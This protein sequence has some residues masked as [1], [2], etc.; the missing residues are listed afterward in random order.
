MREEGTAA[1]KQETGGSSHS[2]TGRGR[3]GRGRQKGDREREREAESVG[4][5]Q[6]GG[7]TEIGSESAMLMDTG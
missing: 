1:E 6:G 5:R 2:S 3:V 4:E 7:V